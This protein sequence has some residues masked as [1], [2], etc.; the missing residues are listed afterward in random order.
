VARGIQQVSL[1]LYERGVLDDAALER[2]LSD[3]ELDEA[4]FLAR[5]GEEG[6][7]EAD[8]VAALAQRSGLPGIDLSKSVLAL[9]PLDLIPRA[10]AETDLMLP[11]SS[12]GG[13]LHVAMLSPED[14]ARATDEVRFISG[15]D[16]S[17][18]VAIAGSLERTIAEAYD[19]RERGESFLRGS[20]VGPG[21]PRSR[22]S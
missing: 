19:A 11:L 6:Y 10:V 16:V 18:Y 5:L 3:P 8:L 15:M 20:A 14:A 4:R 21:S 7:A 13:R 22:A 17:T 12:E 1:I 9:K 2:A